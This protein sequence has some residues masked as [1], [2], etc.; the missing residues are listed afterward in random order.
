M[1]KIKA[2]ALNLAYVAAVDDR[3]PAG[4]HLAEHV[5]A[6]SRPQLDGALAYLSLTAAAACHAP[7][8]ELLTLPGSW[9]D[10][11]SAARL[12]SRQDAE[13]RLAEALA[14]AR[15]ALDDLSSH[16]YN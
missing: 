8:A 15:S 12:L 2:I 7:R 13:K 14:F 4:G 10:Q 16:T 6:L 11:I 1:E 3:D 9:T 5:A